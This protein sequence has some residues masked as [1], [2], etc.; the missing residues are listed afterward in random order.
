MDKGKGL[1]FWKIM[2]TRRR[3][4]I[5]S[6]RLSKMSSSSSITRPL[7][8]QPGTRSLKRLRQ[9]RNVLLPQPE[10][11]TT[12]VMRPRSIE[13]VRSRSTVRA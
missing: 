3:S 13:S 10:G 5:K 11:P 4:A 2:P 7:T 12:A 9:A 8:A 1:G 6:V